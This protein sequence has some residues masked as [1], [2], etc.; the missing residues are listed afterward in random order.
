M[1]WRNFFS[2]APGGPL[3]ELVDKQAEGDRDK[4]R[5]WIPIRDKHPSIVKAPERHVEG[6]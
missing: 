5:R 2:F 4:N 1:R 6:A 3:L